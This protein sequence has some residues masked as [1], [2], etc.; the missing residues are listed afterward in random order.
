MIFKMIK[1]IVLANA[2]TFVVVVF[3]LLFALFV[4][5]LPNASFILTQSWFHF[6][7]LGSVHATVVKISFAAII[8]G[9]IT[10]GISVWLFTYFCAFLYNKWSK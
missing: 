1:A 10:L 2:V 3:Y 8:L 4:E 9:V 5:F 7:N 6:L